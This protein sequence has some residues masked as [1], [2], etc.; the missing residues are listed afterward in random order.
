MEYEIYVL[1]LIKQVTSTS[2][3][4]RLSNSF[5]FVIS[6]KD[7]EHAVGALY[8]ARKMTKVFANQI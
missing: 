6:T 3:L 7:R 2:G 8:C 1:K 4:F 5:H